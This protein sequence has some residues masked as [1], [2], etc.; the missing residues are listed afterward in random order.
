MSHK[1]AIISA[2]DGLS[3]DIR[4]RSAWVGA[5]RRFR[6]NK[7]AV[8]GLAYAI[9]ILVVAVFVPVLAPY[10]YD[11]VN[12]DHS[13][14]APTWAYP[15]GTDELGR[16]LLSRVMYGA[17]PMLM[18]GV[19]TQ[20]VGLAIGVP[21]GIASGYVGGIFDWMVMRLIEFFSAL[22]SYLIVLYLV[23]ILEPSTKN[24][25]LALSVSSWVRSCRLVR[26]LTLSVREHDYVEAATALGLRPHR[27]LIFHVL[28]QAASL[29]MWG[30]A[31]GIPGA[32]LAEAG[33][34]YLGLGIRPP[35]PSW[36][37]MLTTGQAYMAF[38]PNMLLIPALLI[39]ISI[40]SFQMLA[41]GLREAMDVNVNV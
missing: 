36:G 37:Q 41:D 26:G 15:F 30:F 11:K 38:R 40:L 32:A 20:I 21:L 4:Y 8:L 1:G 3:S 16:D 31:A 34:S 28:P 10:P 5:W 14:E 22:P 13:M 25:I 17:R 18:V 33:L 19:F 27:I 2:T 6:Q 7:G 12:Y 29:L 39:M 24:L 9:L 35:N 23:M